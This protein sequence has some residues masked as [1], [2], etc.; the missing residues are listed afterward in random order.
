MESV[1][2][3]FSFGGLNSILLYLNFFLREWLHSNLGTLVCILPQILQNHPRAF[4]CPSSSS[5]Y[6][7][8]RRTSL[9]AAFLPPKFHSHIP[10]FIL[11][12]HRVGSG[13]VQTAYPLPEKAFFSEEQHFF[14][15]DQLFLSII[16]FL[17]SLKLP[18]QSSWPLSSGKNII[19]P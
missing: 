18:L 2:W 9:A 6:C 7:Q 13:T 3:H 15:S 11:Q 4:F 16:S 10:H 19:P 12:H 8:Y 17:H 5:F 14:R 1:K